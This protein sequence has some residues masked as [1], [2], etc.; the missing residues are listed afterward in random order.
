MNWDGSLEHMWTYRFIEAC[1]VEAIPILFRKTPLSYKFVNDF[2]FLWDDEILDLFS[3]KNYSEY[4]DKAKNNRILAKQKFC[5]TD[6]EI[7]LIQSTLS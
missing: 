5:F 4:L 3:S 7:E 1:F 6:K 2:Y